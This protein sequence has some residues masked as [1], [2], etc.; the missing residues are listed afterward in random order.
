MNS[1]AC[2]FARPVKKVSAAGGFSCCEKSVVLPANV[3]ATMRFE[4]VRALSSGKERVSCVQVKSGMIAG[5]CEL[6]GVIL[7]LKRIQTLNF[8][9]H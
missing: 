6:A 8:Y 5:F 2:Q 3:S 4:L 7:N 9:L 1:E